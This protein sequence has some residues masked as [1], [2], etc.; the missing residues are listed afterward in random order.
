[1]AKLRNTTARE[2]RKADLW[3]EISTDNFLTRKEEC[4]KLECV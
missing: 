3:V 2:V 4:Y 1:M